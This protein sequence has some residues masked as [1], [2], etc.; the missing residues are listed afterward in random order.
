MW[1]AIII[2]ANKH[3]TNKLHI[4]KTFLY[5]YVLLIAVPTHTSPIKPA[6]TPIN[7]KLL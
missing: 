2:T 4:R 1:I 6:I 7:T 5:D 3:V